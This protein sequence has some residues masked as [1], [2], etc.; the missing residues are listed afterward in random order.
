MTSGCQIDRILFCLDVLFLA[1][2]VRPEHYIKLIDGNLEEDQFSL[3]FCKHRWIE[4][5]KVVDN[6]AI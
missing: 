6:R 1:S 4:S 5:S 2:P 3:K